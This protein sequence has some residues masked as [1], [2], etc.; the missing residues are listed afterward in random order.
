MAVVVFHTVFTDLFPM[1]VFL[2]LRFAVVPDSGEPTRGKIDTGK[3]TNTRGQQPQSRITQ[4][5]GTEKESAHTDETRNFIHSH[6]NW[7]HKYTLIRGE[8]CV[9]GWWERERERE[10]EPRL[11]RVRWDGLRARSTQTNIWSCSDLYWVDG[12]IL[13]Q[14]NWLWYIYTYNDTVKNAKTDGKLNWHQQ[15]DTTEQ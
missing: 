4:M 11:T 6:K 5:H 7:K 14:Y 13:K 8:L 15:F 12:S 3:L 2:L 10:R 1:C 9:A